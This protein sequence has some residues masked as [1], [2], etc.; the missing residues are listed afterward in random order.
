MENRMK[1]PYLPETRK[2][3]Q[4]SVCLYYTRTAVFCKESQVQAVL[5]FAFSSLSEH[6][7]ITNVF[8]PS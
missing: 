6:L 1:N 7:E 5:R 8:Y 2:M 3:P 4:N